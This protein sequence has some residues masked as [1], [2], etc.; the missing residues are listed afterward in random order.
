M[1]AALKSGSLGLMMSLLAA[2]TAMAE[3]NITV[4]AYSGLFRSATPRR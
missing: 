1:K 4:M 3:T 2:G